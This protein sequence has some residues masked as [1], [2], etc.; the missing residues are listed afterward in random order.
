ML[1]NILR[2]PLRRPAQQYILTYAAYGAGAGSRRTARRGE[3]RARRSVQEGMAG[4]L[5]TC[6][7]V[8]LSFLLTAVGSFLILLHAAWVILRHPFQALK[9][10][11]RDGKEIELHVSHKIHYG[12]CGILIRNLVGVHGGT[13]K[14]VTV[15]YYKKLLQC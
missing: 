7:F 14:G 12:T 9:K 10:T 13:P 6:S 8:L 15:L 5:A 11:P 2:N 3:G 1:L 4:L